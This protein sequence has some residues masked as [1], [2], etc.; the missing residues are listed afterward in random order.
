M[1]DLVATVS[2]E[3]LTQMALHAGKESIHMY[4]I[5]GTGPSV[6]V[7]R[8]PLICLPFELS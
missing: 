3:E 4:V 2:Q 8:S 5:R 1:Q 6:R 7:F